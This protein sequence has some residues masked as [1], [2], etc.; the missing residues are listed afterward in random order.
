MGISNPIN[1]ELANILMKLGLIEQSGKGINTIVNHYGEEVFNFT[2]NYLQV[3]L[4][5]NKYAM[6]Q[7]E[8]INE[9]I[10]DLETQI[11]NLIKINPFI[12]RNEL[13]NITKKSDA[14]IYRMLR[15]LKEKG[16]IVRV[17]SRKSGYWKIKE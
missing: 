15:K 5:Y 12:T 14:S 9:A 4:P 2:D 1:P 7:N 6:S 11:I 10:N 16:I 17:G 8:A 13:V 3:N